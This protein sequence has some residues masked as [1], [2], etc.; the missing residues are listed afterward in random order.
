MNV[1]PA[2]EELSPADDGHIGDAP[3]A[4]PRRP[5]P[6]LSALMGGQTWRSARWF[7]LAAGIGILLLI[8]GQFLGSSERGAGLSILPEAGGGGAPGAG[9]AAGTGS[10]VFGQPPGGAGSG[11]FADGSIEGA[12]A[13]LAALLSEHLT[14]VAGAGSVHVMVSLASGPEHQYGSEGDKTRRH[15]EE[16]D[17]QGGKRT[18]TET[19]ESMRVIWQPTAGSQREPALE[20]V[21]NVQ[22][23]GVLVVAPGAHDPAVKA[24]LH[25]AVQTLLDLPSHRINVV[26]GG[27]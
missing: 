27:G 1:A 5:A 2:R 14:R 8:A 20:K 13:R 16:T 22:V 6:V 3:S 25:G 19:T 7:V 23:R 4:P 9:G 21:M 10:S 18:V 17:P 26:P 15:T 12:E 11:P 24:R